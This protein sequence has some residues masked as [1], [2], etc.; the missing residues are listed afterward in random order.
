MKETEVEAKPAKKAKAPAPRRLRSRR[1]PTLSRRR[2]R[3]AKAAKADVVRR[4]LADLGVGPVLKE[5]LTEAATARWPRS[6]SS[7][8]RHRQARRRAQP[9]RPHRARGWWRRPRN[10]GGQAAGAGRQRCCGRQGIR[11]VERLEGDQPWHAGKL[12]VR[13]ATVVTPDW[14]AL[15]SKK[16]GGETI[17][18]GD[19]IV[20]NAARP[21]I[22]A[23]TSASA[24]IIRFALESGPSRAQE[25]NGRT[26]VSVNPMRRPRSSR[27]RTITPAPHLGN[28]CLA[29]PG[30]GSGRSAAISPFFFTLEGLP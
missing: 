3:Q 26:Y 10:A 14:S 11:V 13:R 12:A 9:R 17:I 21:G 24:R 20:V 15:A 22:P 16:F 25:A 1:W 29:E 27:F 7:R 30:K 19:I 5:K 28:R 18:P 23:S 8:R 4:H 6:R 2:S